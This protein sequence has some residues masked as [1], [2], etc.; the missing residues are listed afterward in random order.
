MLVSFEYGIN[1]LEC[2]TLSLDPVEDLPLLEENGQ[3][4]GCDIQ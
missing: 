1:F 3:S 4:V 2:F